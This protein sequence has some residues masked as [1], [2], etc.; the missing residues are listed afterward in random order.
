MSNDYRVYIRHMLDAIQAIEIYTRKI[1]WSKFKKTPLLQ[2]GVVR[3]LEIIG[4]P[5]KRIPSHIR[6]K[7][8][9][10]DWRKVAG[11]RDVLIH[12]YLGVD[13][14]IVWEVV[15]NQLAALKRK[16]RKIL[17]SQKKSYGK[18]K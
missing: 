10:I 5:S 11:M 1:T 17:K 13:L 8:P 18:E 15:E 16:L 2:D 14:E 9:D 7:Y 6:N 12:D 4:E 3:K